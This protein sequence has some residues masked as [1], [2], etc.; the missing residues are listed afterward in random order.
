M[1][2]ILENT[3][4]ELHFEEIWGCTAITINKCIGKVDLFLNQNKKSV[5]KETHLQV[6]IYHTYQLLPFYIRSAS[7]AR[8][9]AVFVV[10]NDLLHSVMWIVIIKKSVG[11]YPMKK[12]KT[13]S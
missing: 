1:N 9:I 8:G 7:G 11:N 2:F 5:V 12:E 13:S 10:Y 4:E 6:Y 3:T